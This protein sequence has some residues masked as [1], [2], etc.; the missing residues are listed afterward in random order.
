MEEPVMAHSAGIDGTSRASEWTI[1]VSTAKRFGQG[2][3]VG[4]CI[5][6]REEAGGL[7]FDPETIK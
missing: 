2:L 6:S 7:M 3:I 5:G 1:E 4:S